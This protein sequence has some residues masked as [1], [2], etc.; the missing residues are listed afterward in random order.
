MCR[1]VAELDAVNSH[2]SKY[3]LTVD[4]LINFERYKQLSIKL[5]VYQVPPDSVG[6][7][8]ERHIEYLREKVETENYD[9]EAEN[10]RRRLLQKREKKDYRDRNEEW[11]DSGFK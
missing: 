11:I 9:D 6:N 4:D 2:L 1:V 5:P 10:K 3:P 7:R 8:Q